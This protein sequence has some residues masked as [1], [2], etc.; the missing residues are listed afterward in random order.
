M[1]GSWDVRDAIWPIR[2]FS[3]LFV[4]YWLNDSVVHVVPLCHRQGQRNLYDPR[5]H[6]NDHII[7]LTCSYFGA[8]GIVP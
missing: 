3:A 5:G 8:R 6:A 7:V 1:G 4:G 2:T